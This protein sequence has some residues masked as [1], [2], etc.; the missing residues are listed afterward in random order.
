MDVQNDLEDNPPQ[1]VLPTE[2]LNLVFRHIDDDAFVWVV[3]RQLSRMLRAE[4]DFLF[5]SRQLKEC[6]IYWPQSGMIATSPLL[7]R[8][9][10]SHTS[11]DGD[12]ACFKVSVAVK[13]R[14][15]KAP[16][17]H[18]FEA[19]VATYEKTQ[20]TQKTNERRERQFGS[21]PVTRIGVGPND[22]YMS[23]MAL[24][25]LQTHGD[26]ELVSFDWKALFALIYQERYVIFLQRAANNIASPSMMT[27]P[28][29]HPIVIAA[30]FLR[31]HQHD[32]TED[33]SIRTEVRRSRYQH[34][35]PPDERP[36]GFASRETF[37]FWKSIDDQLKNLDQYRDSVRLRELIAAR[38]LQWVD[39]ECGG[40]WV[41]VSHS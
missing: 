8:L 14:S 38:G 6:T 7:A 40:G 28:T 19:A 30:R 17:F 33:F 18:D 36:Y 24:P 32:T 27:L 35:A 22:T 16:S 21:M 34:L 2:L 26:L 31:S 4:V 29:K 23:D 12:I 15:G 10:F 39:N 13:P 5:R 37:L 3:C 9:D 11:D 41:E 20:N 1:Q 25:A